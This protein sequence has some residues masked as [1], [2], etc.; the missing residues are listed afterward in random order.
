LNTTHIY[1]F[2]PR[3]LKKLFEV[4][5]KFE[6][7]DLVIFNHKCPFQNKRKILKNIMRGNF[8]EGEYFKTLS[9]STYL[10]LLFLLGGKTIEEQKNDPK[11]RQHEVIRVIL[12]KK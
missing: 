2:T 9:A 5:S 6:I 7:I 3:S 8:K 11:G 10:L 1:N 4:N 12:R